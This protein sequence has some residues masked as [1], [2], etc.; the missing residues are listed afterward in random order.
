MIF[1]DMS[2]VIYLYVYNLP[3]SLSLVISN[4]IMMCLHVIFFIIISVWTSLNSYIC[5]FIDF[6]R[7]EKFQPIVLTSSLPFLWTL[8]KVIDSHFVFYVFISLCD[9]FWILYITVSSHS[10]T[11]SSETSSLSLILYKVSLISC[12]FFFPRNLIYILLYL[13]FL[14]SYS[15]YSLSSWKY[16]ANL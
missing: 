8:V 12:I 10:L 16:E 2:T 14:S 11:F 15:C 9:S 7:L 3:S 6:T 4:L 13:P 5:K 1:D